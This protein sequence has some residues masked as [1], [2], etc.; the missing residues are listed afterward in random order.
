MT[1]EVRPYGVKCNIQCQYCYQ[2]AVRENSN[3]SP[4]YDIA[5]IKASVEAEG[6]PFTLFGGEPLMMPIAGL[7]ELWSWGF[8]KFGSNGLQT[9]GTLLRSEHLRL[10][11][12]YNVRVGISVDGPGELNSA[13]RAGDER[14]TARA[15][16]KTQRA[17]EWLCRENIKPGLIVTLHRANA[18]A[19]KLPIM[20][21]WVAGLDAL[22]IQS[23]RLHTLEVDSE[24][25]RTELSLDQAELLRAFHN[26]HDLE[27]SLKNM[28]FDVFKDLRRLLLGDDNRTSCVWNAC[29]PYTTRAVNGIEGNGQRSNCGRTNK[30]GV[31]FVKA[32]R[33]AYHRY[34]ALYHTPQ[35]FGGCAGCRF[36]VFCKGQC[37]G[38]AI[39]GDWRNRTEHCELWKNLFAR[40]ENDLIREDQIPL[41]IG[42]ERTRVE[43]AFISYWSKGQTPRIEAIVAQLGKADRAV[44]RFESRTADN[45]GKS[46]PR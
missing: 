32:D 36:F 38:T 22:G 11:K 34:I 33:P 10:I 35:Q 20:N 24:A 13:R 3:S 17:I 26:F 37:P 27:S 30:D 18:T 6:G 45:L 19:D 14:G 2:N 5:A 40:I 25:V 4:A 21:R 43:E 28:R 7:E 9:N 12:S 15:T 8:E 44:P 16:E 31:D 46:G 1:I 42:S 41:S 29:D 39:G 23:I